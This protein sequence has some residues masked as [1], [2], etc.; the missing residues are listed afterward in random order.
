MV[1][2]LEAYIKGADALTERTGRA[3][4]WLA[5]LLVL[6]VIYDVF[7]RYVLSASSVAVQEL[8]WHVFSLLFL[9]GAAY[10]LKHNKHVRVDVFF[11]R[12]SPKKQA[13]ITILGGLFFLL[14]FTVL[15][16]SSSWTFVA[17]SFR[18]L[19]SSPD[20]GGLPLRFLLKA[21][22]PAGFFLL[23]LQGVAE[24]FRAL[25]FLTGKTVPADGRNHG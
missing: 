18:I 21:A 22:I 11:A 8:E 7:T 13:M 25:L 4:S 1:R 3:V 2:F 10:T 12:M 14:P 16:V 20:P 6:V 17:N 24:I 9:L 15:V 19:E 5:L 23:L